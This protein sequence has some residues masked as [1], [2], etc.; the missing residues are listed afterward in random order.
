MA[1]GGE[2]QGGSL[3]RRGDTRKLSDFRSSESR[4]DRTSLPYTTLMSV[5]A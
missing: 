5:L 1:D 4:M 2:M 3:E